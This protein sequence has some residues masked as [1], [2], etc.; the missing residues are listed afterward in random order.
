MV[1]LLRALGFLD[2]AHV[3]WEVIEM[4]LFIGCLKFFLL[5]F[6][7]LEVQLG[8]DAGV[9]LLVKLVLVLKE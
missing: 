3:V 2:G 1:E 6:F 5:I 7:H 9:Q 4:S 8:L